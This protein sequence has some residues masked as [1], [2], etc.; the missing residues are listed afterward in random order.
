MRLSPYFSQATQAPNNG[1]SNAQDFQPPTRN[2]QTAPANL[3]PGTGK[4]QE[5]ST[6]DILS[7][8]DTRINITRNP[9]D[10]PV[11]VQPVKA[12]IN[13]PFVTI[14]TVVIVVVLYYL[15]SLREKRRMAVIAPPEMPEPNIKPSVTEAPKPKPAPTPKK[16][17]K[18]KS[19]SKRKKR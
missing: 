14:S 2:P 18:K 10:P 6:Q 7:R 16:S 3:Q 4:A 1:A 5:T 15:L 11:P 19:K 13:W 8:Q 17:K 9:A 12:G